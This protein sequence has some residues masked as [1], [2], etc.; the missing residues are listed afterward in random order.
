MLGAID[1][2]TGTVGGGIPAN[3]VFDMQAA[4]ASVGSAMNYGRRSHGL[5]GDEQQAAAAMPTTPGTQSES[6]KRQQPMPG[7]LPPTQ[8][9]FGKRA[10]AEGAIDTGEEDDEEMA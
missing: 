5:G 1:E 7:P 6:G 9:P 4:L 8:N 2:E 3:P 10:D